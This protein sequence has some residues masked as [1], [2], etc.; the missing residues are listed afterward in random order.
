MGIVPSGAKDRSVGSKMINARCE[1]LA[2]KTS[3]NKSLRKRRCL[4]R[5]MVIMNGK[6]WV[7][8][9]NLI[10]LC[11]LLVICLCCGYMDE[12]IADDGEVLQSFSKIND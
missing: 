7:A 9:N 12:W 5:L 8:K 3:F 10:V 1:T 6:N 4:Y 2:G 11:S